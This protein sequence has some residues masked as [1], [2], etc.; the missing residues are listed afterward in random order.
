MMH[1]RLSSPHD[2]YTYCIGTH[3]IRNPDVFASSKF[4]SA[5]H[6]FERSPVDATGAPKGPG[7]FHSDTIQN[8][9]KNVHTWPDS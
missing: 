9:S 1:Y 6:S 5:F 3:G 8:A 7:N 4:R 2:Q